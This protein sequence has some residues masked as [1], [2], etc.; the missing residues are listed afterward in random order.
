MNEWSAHTVT[1]ANKLLAA[2]LMT[3]SLLAPSLSFAE[4]QLPTAPALYSVGE[5][6]VH[7]ARLGNPK[8]SGICGTSTG[9]AA[10]ML[11]KDL[12]AE[13]LPVLAAV[14]ADPAKNGVERVD[15]YPDIT[16]IQPRDAECVSWVSLTVERH[17]ALRVDPIT[18]PRDLV[19]TYWTGGVMIGTTVPNH[20]SAIDNAFMKLSQQLARQ[21]ATDQPPSLGGTT[22]PD[23]PKQ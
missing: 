5:M 10:K 20:P 2:A 3:G 12:Q 11:L 13:H 9:E 4:E 19:V 6:Q 18:T 21:Y 14:G 1:N 16:T 8:A 23:L 17:A 22:V 7:Y 15:I